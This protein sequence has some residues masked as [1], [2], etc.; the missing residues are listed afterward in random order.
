MPLSSRHTGSMSRL[1]RT[2][3]SFQVAPTNPTTTAL[4][5]G[6][7]PGLTTIE[8]KYGEAGGFAG[9]QLPNPNN[10]PTRGPRK[11]LLPGGV[12]IKPPFTPTTPVRL[13]TSN[14][15]MTSKIVRAERMPPSTL[16]KGCRPFM[17]NG[18]DGMKGP[19]HAVA[20]GTP[21]KYGNGALLAVSVIGPG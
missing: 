16:R 4:A 7:A 3:D 9:M 12:Y 11:K 19:D 5:I 21:P 10:T 20:A 14:C 6:T 1:R 8:G 18:P 15:G 17:G 2:S 13:V